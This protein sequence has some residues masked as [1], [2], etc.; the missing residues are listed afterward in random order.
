MAKEIASLTL[1]VKDYNSQEKP[2]FS[3]SYKSRDERGVI[4]KIYQFK[5]KDIQGFQIFLKILANFF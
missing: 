4:V 3:I 5:D 1:N 2:L